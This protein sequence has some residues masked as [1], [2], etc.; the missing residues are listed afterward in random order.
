MIEPYLVNYGVLGLWT[1]FLIYEKYTQHQ[2]MIEA[3]ECLKE[4]IK[5][6]PLLVENIQHLRKK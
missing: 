1:I 2:R 4:E 6:L 5:N 3:L